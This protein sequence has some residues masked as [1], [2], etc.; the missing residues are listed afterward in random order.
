MFAF[1]RQPDGTVHPAVK[2]AGAGVVG[3]AAAA[4]AIAAVFIEPFE[5][6]ASKP[7]VDRVGTGHPIT[8]CY[9]ETKA[10]APVPPMGT[11]FTKAECTKE[12]EHDLQTKYDPAVRK[13]IHVALPPHREAALI[14]F[15]YNLGPGPLCN[16]PVGRYLNAGNVPAG[17][18]AMLAYDHAAGKRLPGLT[19]RRQAERALCIRND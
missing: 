18:N 3:T 15:V 10:D 5:G 6:Y 1:L 13:C 12:L 17:C 4:I 16:G 14:S 19:R 2:V 8:W 11:L 9:G 7:Y